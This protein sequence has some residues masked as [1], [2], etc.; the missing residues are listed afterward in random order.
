[1][2]GLLTKEKINEKYPVTEEM[3]IEELPKKKGLNKKK[4]KKIQNRIIENK[5]LLIEMAIQGYMEKHKSSY[6]DAKTHIYESMNEPPSIN[7]KEVETTIE[8]IE[9]NNVAKL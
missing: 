7:D 4:V 1:M 5:S 6:E 9:D 2:G 8:E 3:A